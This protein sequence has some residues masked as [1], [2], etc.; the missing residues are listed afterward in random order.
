[1]RKKNNL[2]ALLAVGDFYKVTNKPDR[3]EMFCHSK[4][5]MAIRREEYRVAREIFQTM[6]N[7]TT[8]GKVLS[9]PAVVI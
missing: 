5:N 2:F 3:N 4:G 8:A 1:M 7:K 6:E 9:L